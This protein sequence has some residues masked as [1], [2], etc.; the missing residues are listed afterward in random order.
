MGKG[1]GIRVRCSGCTGFY[2]NY[3][4]QITYMSYFSMK[5]LVCCICNMKSK[6]I[7]TQLLENKGH[8]MS[9]LSLLLLSA[10]LFAVPSPLSFLYW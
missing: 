7:E 4:S 3:G 5:Y 1:V 10:Y 6:F 9:V 8:T 2:T